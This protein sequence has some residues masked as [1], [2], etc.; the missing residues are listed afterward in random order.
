MKSPHKLQFMK[1]QEAS[2]ILLQMSPTIHAENAVKGFWDEPRTV[3]MILALI[4]SE[5]SEALEAARKDRFTKFFP[6]FEE[7]DSPQEYATVF[8][9]VI[10]DTYEDELAD[11][12]IRMLDMFGMKEMKD[13]SGIL[14]FTIPEKA[15]FGFDWAT[16]TWSSEE[17]EL[18]Y[19]E[20]EV[21]FW[22]NVSMVYPQERP[23]IKYDIKSQCIGEQLFRI[24][25]TLSRC[26]PMS[27]FDADSADMTSS[28]YDN[29]W[30]AFCMTLC[31]CEHKGI[32]IVAHVNA[33]LAYNKTRPFKHGKKF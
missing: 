10:K 20:K 1:I 26:M 32:D 18:K 14:D 6:N 4:N 28:F 16:G 27:R 11:V 25:Y 19:T 12:V 7:C 29:L 8:E 31:L 21:E 23:F 24:T 22:D 15:A 33:K 30:S 2:G 17:D 9:T 3:G 13:E 5:I